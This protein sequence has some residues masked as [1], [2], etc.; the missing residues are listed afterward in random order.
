MKMP[1]TPVHPL[2]GK[3]AYPI[4]IRISMLLSTAILTLFFLFYPR[5]LSVWDSN[6]SSIDQHIIEQVEIPQTQQIDNIVT[7]AR[8]SIPVP[9]EDEEIADDLTLDELNFDEF[10]AW[11]DA[12]PPP[13]DGGPKVKFIPYDEA[14]VPIGG[15]SAIRKNIIYPKIAM[16]AGVE[17]IV[18]IQAFI[19]KKGR[20]KDAIVMRG[21]PGSGLNEAAISAIRKTRFKPAKQRDRTI[22]VWMSIPVNFKLNKG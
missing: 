12:P 21:I 7:P 9:S 16:E 2:F 10:M 11:D 20:V 4:T 19:D 5:Q 6:I 3:A 14:P 18:I 22:G 1:H 13:S 8:P 15:I 17:G